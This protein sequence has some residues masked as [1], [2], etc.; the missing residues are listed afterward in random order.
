M[1]FLVSICAISTVSASEN[2]SDTT[3]IDDAISEDVVTSFDEDL[4]AEV[5]D[6]AVS[7]QEDNNDVE[8]QDVLAGQQDDV[9]S[10]TPISYLDYKIDLNDNGYEISA[11]DGGTIYYYME[12]CQTYALNLIISILH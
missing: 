10:A 1:L 2:V 3:A 9:L 7:A 6:N 12:P 5:E 11:K 8:S 4:S